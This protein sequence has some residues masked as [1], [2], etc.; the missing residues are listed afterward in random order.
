[1]GSHRSVD[2]PRGGVERHGLDEI[3]PIF[4]RLEARF[5][6]CTLC[7]H[8]VIAAGASGDF[9]YVVAYE[10]T[11]ASLNGSPALPYTLRAT[12]VFRREDGEWKVVHRHADAAS[13]NAAELVQLLVATDT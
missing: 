12:T 8:E 4:D 13:E 10:H 3:E 11:T 9:A 7:E 2:T 1:M 5:S 6:D